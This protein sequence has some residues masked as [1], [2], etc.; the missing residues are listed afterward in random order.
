MAKLGLNDV[1]QNSVEQSE[2]LLPR[3]AK[4]LDRSLSESL[5]KRLIKKS[6]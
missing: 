1:E 3:P 5:G 6:S 2:E 4:M